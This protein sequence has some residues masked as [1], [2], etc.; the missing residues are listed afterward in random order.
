MAL[1]RDNELS[2][3]RSTFSG[4]SANGFGG[5][6]AVENTTVSI[7]HSA[8]VKNI[9]DA[10]E[11]D[12]GDGGG[13]Y[14]E[15]STSLTMKNTII[16]LNKDKSPVDLSHPD[17]S[18]DATSS[19]TFNTMG[20]NFIGDNETVSSAF[21][22]PA[23]PGGQNLQGDYVGDTA[24]PLEPVL[25]TLH[26]NGGPTNTHVPLRSSIKVTAPWLRWISAALVTQVPL[27]LLGWLMMPLFSMPL[28]PVI[29][30]PW[31]KVR[32]PK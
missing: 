25:G 19:V 12:Y 9:A 15:G 6:L 2:I 13:L 20:F 1:Y 22:M 18:L 7:F 17:I 8:F 16:A 23:F 21:P 28:M 27:T 11:D 5:A 29:L 14:L 32:S 4:N 24:A 10:N 3:Y 26:N 31:K 30:V